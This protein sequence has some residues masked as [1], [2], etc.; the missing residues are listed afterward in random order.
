M[1]IK[2]S[3]ILR[4]RRV[5]EPEEIK[6]TKDQKKEFLERVRNYNLYKKAIYNEHDFIEIADELAEVAKIAE[7][8]TLEKVDDSFDAVTVKRNLKELRK[9][10]DEFHKVASESQI[11]KQRMMGLFED[12][13]NILNR[14]Y[15]IRSEKK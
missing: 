14:Y 13:G 5:L 1:S 10:S 8:L 6:L 11:L 2:L 7:Q 9:L 12:M 4:E 15:E 3:K